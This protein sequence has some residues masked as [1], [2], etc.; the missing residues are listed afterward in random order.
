[1]AEYTLPDLPYDYDALEPHISGRI[2]ELHHDKHH[3]TYVA[4]ANTALERLAEARDKGALET[5]NLYE[6]NLTFNLA[7]LWVN[8][9][10]D[11][12][13]RPVGGEV[14]PEHRVVDVPREV[15]RQVLLVQVDRLECALVP[16][17]SQALEGRVGSGDVG[18]MVLVV[19]QLHDPAGDVRLEC[20][21]VVGKV[22]EG[23]LS[24]GFLRSGRGRATSCLGEHHRHTRHS[25]SAA[26]SP[27][28]RVG[29][30]G[31]RR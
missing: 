4:G 20:V 9:S 1:M 7:V 8:L 18:P 19:V 10:P 31:G 14:H 11:G 21:V 29:G 6:K 23:V 13:D 30:R 27:A 5:V 17:L 28:V 12:G 15:E 2:M 22:G 16:G 3:G 26:W 25:H 24:H